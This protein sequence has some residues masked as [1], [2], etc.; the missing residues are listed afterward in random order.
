[1]LLY[2]A[3]AVNNMILPA[4]SLI[5]T[6]QAAPTAKTMAKVKQLLDYVATQEEAIITYRASDMVSSVHKKPDTATRKRHKAK[7]VATFIF[8]TTTPPHQ[9]MEQFSQLQ[10]L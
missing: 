9:T 8:Q 6:K 5:A 4:L 1:M 7:Q 10:Q 3:R 2:Y